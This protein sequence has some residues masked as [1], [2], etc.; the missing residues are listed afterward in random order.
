MSHDEH[1]D[2][3]RGAPHPPEEEYGPY[4]TSTYPNYSSSRAYPAPVRAAAVATVEQAAAAMPDTTITLF[5]RWAAGASD[6]QFNALAGA[7]GGFTSGVVTC[8]LDV[9]KTKLQAQGGFNPIAKGRH[10]GH[11]KLYNGL[12]GTAGVIWREEGIRGMYRGLG[13]IV[14]GY[15]PTW[16]VWFT[17]YNKSKDWMKQR[18]DN[19]V[20]INFWSSIIAGASS[21]I[22]TNPIWVI[23]TRLM[24]QSVAHDPGK[25]YSQFPKSSNTPTSRP[26]LHS[27]WHYS[28]TVDAARKMYTSEG[29]LSFYSGLTPALLGLTHVAVQFPAYEYLKTKFTGQ[30]MGEPAHGDAQES[31]WMGILCASI[32]SKI[33]ASSATYPHE[34]IRTRLQTQRRPVAGAEYL[35]G[36]GIKV[37][38]SMLG[39]EAKKQQ[40]ISPKYRGV[41]STFRTILKEEG[42]RAFYAGM[43]TNM[44]RAVPAA[45]VTMLTYEFVMKQLNQARDEGK[46]KK[47]RGLEP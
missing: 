42:W 36:L 20:F 47:G 15:L 32:L 41:A 46:R 12:L 27:N 9:I 25:H 17:V 34:V 38:E 18:H 3:Q 4:P 16:A 35:L 1:H 23:K 39:D 37:P 28:S 45:T 7:V 33:M 10:V 21:T 5:E 24:S 44:M 43:G 31:Q 22:V 14:L 30:G 6:S 29:I 26:T 8:P 19:A 13:P 2:P 40:P 11:P